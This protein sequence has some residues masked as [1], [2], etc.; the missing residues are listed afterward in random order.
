MSDLDNAVVAGMLKA[1]EIGVK[2]LASDCEVILQSA[3][4]SMQGEAK[5]SDRFIGEVIQNVAEL[6]DRNSPD[7]WPEAMLVTSEELQEI[8]ISVHEDVPA[9]TYPPSASAEIARLQKEL[10]EARKDAER[11]QWLRENY[12]G[13]EMFR[14]STIPHVTLDREIDSAMKG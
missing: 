12:H 5:L 4:A 13:F 1:K 2:M 6:P 14:K 9:V 7:D 8:L 10:E 11:Y 3:I